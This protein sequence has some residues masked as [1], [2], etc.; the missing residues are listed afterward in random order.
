MSNLSIYLCLF[1]FFLPVSYSFQVFH[2]QKF[3]V[4]KEVIEKQRKK[5]ICICISISIRS[6]QVTQCVK[7]LPVM[8][9]LQGDVFDSWSGR[10]PREGYGKPLQHSCL[11]NTMDRGFWQGYSSRGCEESDTTEATDLA[12]SSVC[13]STYVS[14]C[15][16]I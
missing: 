13:L 14:V 4:R 10:C 7:N 9:E 8:K 12:Y 3:Q 6:S 2:L 5:L 11:R 1:H 15:I 16:D